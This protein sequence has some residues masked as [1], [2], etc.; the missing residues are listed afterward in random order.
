MNIF[1]PSAILLQQAQAA[2]P[3]STFT[4]SIRHSKIIK[5]NVAVL[6]I[7]QLLS[8]ATIRSLKVVK[9]MLNFAVMVSLSIPL[10]MVQAVLIVSSQLL[11]V[12]KFSMALFALF[13]VPT[14]PQ[15]GA[16][17]LPPKKLFE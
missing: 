1:L 7:N 4:S 5:L 2:V 8:I 10:S 11:R 9:Q 6:M 17:M 12:L 13:V 14:S 16:L 3:S 15:T